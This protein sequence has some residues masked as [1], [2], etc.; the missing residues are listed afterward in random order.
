MADTSKTALPLVDFARLRSAETRDEELAKLR[1]ALFT[2]GFLYLV[3]SG[4]EETA[5]ELH[6]SLPGLFALP[7]EKKQAV[8]MLNSPSFLGYT[9]LGA[10]MTAGGTDMREAR[11]PIPQRIKI[12]FDIG[13]ATEDAWKEGAPTWTKMEG[14]SQYP[15]YPGFKPL[16][17][18]YLRRMTDLSTEFLE[19]VAESLSLLRG[20][21]DPFLGRM[22]RLKLIRYPPAAAG[23]VGVGPHK[24]STGLFTFLSQDS[25][26]G[27]QV[28][29]KSGEWIDA[30]P[31]EGS[32]V[33][34]VQQGFEAVTGGVCPATTHRVI[35]PT[36]VTRYSIPF[37]QGV[38]YELTLDTLKVSAAH[39]VSKIPVS[40]DAKKRAVD[41]PSE[42]LSPLYS[43]LGEARLRNRILSHPDVG[44][45]WYP[46]LYEKYRQQ[47][48]V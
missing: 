36:S 7:A 38:N 47:T 17:G 10:E 30:P 41:V 15:D 40:D 1:H 35:S 2:I 18:E 34:N 39:I 22:H 12:Q 44:Q 9:Q 46:D 48:L 20:T 11:K 33:V 25:V 24:D 28:L 13:T 32:L 5:A 19:A 16:V 45:K 21:F 14:T 3:N 23:S 6:G 37:F 4:L 26:G 29:S 8:A 43:S 42:F 31:I 27:L